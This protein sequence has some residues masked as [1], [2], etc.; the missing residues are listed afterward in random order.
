MSKSKIF[1]FSLLLSLLFAGSVLAYQDIADPL[2]REAAHIAVS[3]GLMEEYSENAFSK[4]DFLTRGEFASLTVKMLGFNETILYNNFTI[5]PDVK[6][7]S[8]DAP[9]INAAVRKYQILRGFPDGTFKPEAELTYAQAITIYLNVLGYTIEDIGPFWPENYMTK[10]EQLGLAKISG[11][12]ANTPLKRSQGAL[13]A[14]QLLQTKTKSNTLFLN[15][16]YPNILEDALLLN[17]WQTQADLSKGQSE[18]LING[19]EQQFTLLNTPA[20]SLIGQKGRLIYDLNEENKILGFLPEIS[21]FIEGEIINSYA[22]RLETNRGSYNIPRNTEVYFNGK[23]ELYQLSWFNLTPEQPVRIY[24]DQFGK[25]NFITVTNT[26]SLT[27]S[28]IYQVNSDEKVPEDALVYKGGHLIK[29]SQ[30]KK[31]DVVS[32]DGRE[33]IYYVSDTKL[34]GY[35]QKGYPSYSYPEKITVFDQE[36][37]LSEEAARSFERIRLNSQVILFFDVLGQPVGAVPAAEFSY[38]QIGVLK[39]IDSAGNAQIELLNGMEINGR[40]NLSSHELVYSAYQ[41][42]INGLLTLKG[43]LVEVSQNM[44]MESFNVFAY[45]LT[46]QVKA[47]WDLKNWSIDSNKVSQDVKIFMQVTEDAPLLPLAFS[48]LDSEK[49]KEEDIRFVVKDRYN[50]IIAIVLADVSSKGW[51]YGRLKVT[52]IEETLIDGS[53]N[54]YTSV[55]SYQLDVLGPDTHLSF[56][57]RHWPD[58]RY[59]NHP[60]KVPKGMGKPSSFKNFYLEPL[61]M[62]FTANKN[63][64]DFDQGL[65]LGNAYLAFAENMQIYSINYKRFISLI[66]AR[67]NYQSFEAYLDRPLE[68]GGQVIY[69]AVK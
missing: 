25:I 68:S 44:N 12:E 54:P 67:A 46:D 43:Q 65:N 61:E 24:F 39:E 3:L 17:T 34:K 6:S 62:E 5:F 49:V 18:F 37:Q 58:E 29:P 22:D 10:A 40:A 14:V 26:K 20:L 45:T 56:N 63:H 19:E 15:Q 59:N 35:Y 11:S 28:F 13:L 48:D 41:G 27:Y 4:H 32:F 38:R 36:F 51:D 2:E 21:N 9:Y 42:Y 16:L 8:L 30:I 23:V 7:D 33:G 31:Y 53:G 52:P 64:F 47:P 55:T 57:V 69:L 60:V 66:E 1:I 50:Q